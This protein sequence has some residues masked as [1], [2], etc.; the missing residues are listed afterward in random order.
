MQNANS[1]VEIGSS[2]RYLMLPKL[3]WHDIRFIIG[4]ST[5]NL[6]HSNLLQEEVNVLQLTYLLLFCTIL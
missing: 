2:G 5:R 4:T 6:L 3:I 1:A